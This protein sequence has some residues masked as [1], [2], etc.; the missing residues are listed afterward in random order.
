MRE[1]MC[2]DLVLRECV[3][4]EEEEEDD[5]EEEEA[6]EEKEEKEEAADEG[7][8]RPT[9]KGKGSILEVEEVEMSLGILAVGMEDAGEEGRGGVLCISSS[10]CPSDRSATTSTILKD[11]SESDSSRVCPTQR[12]K[13]FPRKTQ[14]R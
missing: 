6:E 12:E 10:P 11:G 9:C 5:E 13:V 1:E 2:L 7:K 8:S 4:P 14:Y 3:F